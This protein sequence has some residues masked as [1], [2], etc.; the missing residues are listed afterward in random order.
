MTEPSDAFF[1]SGSSTSSRLRICFSSGMA[2]ARV[3]FTGFFHSLPSGGLWSGVCP[4]PSPTPRKK[5]GEDCS[6]P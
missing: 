2:H 6:V 5:F 3:K 1:E 4:A